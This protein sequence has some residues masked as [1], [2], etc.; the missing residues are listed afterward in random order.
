MYGGQGKARTG[1]RRPSLF[2]QRLEW[3]HLPG[4]GPIG[5]ESSHLTC[6]GQEHFGQAAILVSRQHVEQELLLRFHA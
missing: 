4:T 5:L 2:D 3:E 1:L 6:S